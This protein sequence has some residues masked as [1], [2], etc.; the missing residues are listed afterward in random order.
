VVTTTTDA[1]GR[2]VF[3]QIAGLSPA[4][5]DY[6]GHGRLVTATLGIGAQARIA[7][8]S[9]NSDGY[10]ATV[11]D[12]LSRSVYFGARSGR[13]CRQSDFAGWPRD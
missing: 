9:Y 3:E 12:P 6:D 5:Y 10:L 2:V 1:Q 8:F 11:T 7:S 13:A 4:S